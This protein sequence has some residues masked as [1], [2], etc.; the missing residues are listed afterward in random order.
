M[1]ANIFA[2]NSDYEKAKEFLVKAI[3]IEP[4]YVEARYNYAMTMYHNN[5]LERA[6]DILDD[7][8]LIAK[9]ERDN[10][11][12]AGINN[13][14]GIVYARWAKYSQALL[15]FEKFRILGI[16]RFQPLGKIS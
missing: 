14:Y 13:C 9:K 11:G 7:A 2:I 5:Q 16:Y 3:K 12:M 8:M 6:I 4:N 1:L 15:H 10:S